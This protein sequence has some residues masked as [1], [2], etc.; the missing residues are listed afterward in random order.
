MKIAVHSIAETLFEGEAA[1]IIAETPGG[2]IAVL[3]AHIPLIT[4]L[5]GPRLS[6]MSESRG[7]VEIPLRGGVLEVRPQSEA[8]AL[9]ETV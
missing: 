6:L 2:Q 4:M 7:P 8:V 5:R 1:E 9:V 3:E